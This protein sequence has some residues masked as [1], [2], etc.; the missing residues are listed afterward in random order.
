MR[1]LFITWNRIG[2]AVLSSGAIAYLLA[3]HPGCRMTIACG[4]AAAPLFAATPG[5]E[6]VLPMPKRPWAAHWFTLWG[7]VALRRWDLVMDLRGSLLA[8]FLVARRRKVLL[9]SGGSLHRVQHLAKFIGLAVAPAPKI[10]SGAEHRARASQLIPSGGPVL[11][12]GPTANWGGK[13]WPADRFAAA[14][15]RLTGQQDILPGARVAVFGG[16]DE[17]AMAAP[18]LASVA[19]DRLIDLVGNLDL[20]TAYACLE[21]TQLYI[22]NDSALMHLAAASGVPTLGLFG[23]SREEHYGPWGAHCQAVRTDLSYDDILRQ[24][25]YDYRQHISHMTTLSVDKAVAAAEA[26]WRRMARAA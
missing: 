6:R 14:I 19:P 23:P 11:A 10:W 18:V 12:V 1:I 9:G 25:G 13:A 26:L 17:R 5:V 24:P 2:D 7:Q 20:L 8:Q 21:R 22:G 15:A 4:P 16:P 3:R